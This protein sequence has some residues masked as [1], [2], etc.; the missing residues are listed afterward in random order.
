[1]GEYLRHILLIRE[2]WSN[3][4]YLLLSDFIPLFEYFQEHDI[5]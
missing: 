1:M 4:G 2:R 3:Q 5:I